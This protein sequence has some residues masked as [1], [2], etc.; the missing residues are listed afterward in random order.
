MSDF[1]VA[2]GDSFGG[3]DFDSI[4]DSIGDGVGAIS[5]GMMG[6]LFPSG[7]PGFSDSSTTSSG[8]T[9]GSGNQ[10]EFVGGSVNFGNTTIPTWLIVAGVAGVT[11]ILLNRKKRGRK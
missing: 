7:I 1:S 10:I 8:G 2:Q 6:S 5:Q 3:F 11:I 4:G 9:I